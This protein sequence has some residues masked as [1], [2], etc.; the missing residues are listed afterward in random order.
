MREL[1]PTPQS[2]KRM[3]FSIKEVRNLEIEDGKFL[4]FEFRSGGN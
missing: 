1:F 2:P 3:I 4:K